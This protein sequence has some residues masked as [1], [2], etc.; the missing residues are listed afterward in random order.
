[1][2]KVIIACTMLRQELERVMEEA[3]CELPIL[4]IEPALHNDPVRLRSELQTKIDSASKNADTILLAYGFC[5]GALDGLVSQN[6]RLVFP[7]FHDCIHMLTCAGGSYADKEPDCLYFTQAWIESNQFIGKEYE[8]FAELKGKDKALR[9]YRSL[10]RQY[11]AMRFIDTG[12]CEPEQAV[13]ALGPFAQ[14]L[15]LS[16]GITRGSAEPLKSLVT[17]NWDKYFYVA[18]KGETLTLSAFLEKA[19]KLLD[20]EGREE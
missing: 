3:C 18:E 8:R 15:G 13:E 19:G 11:R 16:L 14:Q 10:L 20:A 9:A 4:W 17:G 6:A 2:K 7:L 1:M 5:G 12:Y